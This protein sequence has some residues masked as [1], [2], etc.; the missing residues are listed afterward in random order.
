MPGR[1]PLCG[2]ALPEAISKVRL[3]TRLQTLTSPF[4]AIEKKKLDTQYQTHLAAHQE[5]ANRIAEQRVTGKLRAAE[6]R[7]KRAEKRQQEKLEEARK[8][9]SERLA[10]EGQAARRA[11]EREVR[12]ELIDAR[13]QARDTEAR[14]QK[15]IRQV[16]SESRAVRKQEIDRAVRITARKNDDRIREM[17]TERQRDKVRHQVRE[18]RLQ[19]QLDDM[20][21]KLEG[22]AGEQLGDEAE[23]DL[24][25]VL[26]DTFCPNDKVE[27][28]GRGVRGAD[29]LHHVIDDGKTVGYIVYESKNTGG[30]NK[31]F[32]IQAKK[33][34]TLYDTPHVMIVTR[35][36][37]PKQKGFCVD[38]GIAIIE[39][40]AAVA[41]AKIIREGIIEIARLRLSGR[42]RD[43]KS[44]ELY[45]YIVGDRFR[46]RFRDISDCVSS[47]REQQK[48]E[49]SWHENAWEAETKLHEQI[50]GRHREVEAQ[51]RAIIRRGSDG[52][53]SMQSMPSEEWPNNLA[54]TRGNG[55]SISRSTPA[56]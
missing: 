17:Q 37:P 2:Q 12:Q 47:L 1:C 23:L 9:F 36:F 35:S 52:R 26:R 7:A 5:R 56:Q 20:S 8:D 16:R 41:L 11:A 25:K 14:H 31:A 39:K 10:R 55:R 40:R 43:A 34:Q 15:E 46:T 38:K 54:K 30:W 19:R 3:Q 4:L 29:I 45:E 24:L 50:D 22:T 21:R 53:L 18:A 51:I 42:S 13:K 33:Y 28:I 27:R 48:K 32:V 6:E 49:R 44:Y